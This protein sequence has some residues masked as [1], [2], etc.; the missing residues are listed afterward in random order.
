VNDYLRDASQQEVS[1]KSFRAWGGTLEAG[2]RLV[3][4]EPP[5]GERAQDRVL[6]EELEQVAARLGNSVRI[7]RSAYVHPVVE[8]AWRS[9]ELPALWSAGPSRPSKFLEVEERRLLHVL[10]AAG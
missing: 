6:V 7:C 10:D 1:A 2:R 5:K 9:G 3:P 8:R 4:I